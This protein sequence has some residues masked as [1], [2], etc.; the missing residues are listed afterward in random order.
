MPTKIY[1]DLMQ[2][3]ISSLFFQALEVI[4]HWMLCNRLS[5]TQLDLWGQTMMMILKLEVKMTK[6]M[7]QG[8]SQW[9]ECYFDDRFEP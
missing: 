1:Y 8:K 7:Q 2:K 4:Y 3:M 9:T 5:W 6:M